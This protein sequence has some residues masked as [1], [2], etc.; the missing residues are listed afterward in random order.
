[1][2]FNTGEKIGFSR[3]NPSYLYELNTYT[4]Y[5]AQYDW[6]NFTSYKEFEARVTCPLKNV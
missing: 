2:Q 3:L 6:I 5:I 4:P 1:M